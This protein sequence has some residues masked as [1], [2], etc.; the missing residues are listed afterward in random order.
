MNRQ[1]R[2][3]FAAPATN[4]IECKFVLE[5][6]I[7]YLALK[8]AKEKAIYNRAGI[9]KIRWLKSLDMECF[10][11]GSSIR[12]QRRLQEHAVQIERFGGNLDK[13]HVT[14]DLAKQGFDLIACLRTEEKARTQALKLQGKCRTN[15]RESEFLF[16][17]ADSCRNSTRGLSDPDCRNISALPLSGCCRSGFANT[18]YSQ[19]FVP[20]V[21]SPLNIRVSVDY[22]SPPGAWVSTQEDFSVQVRKCGQVWDTDIGSKRLSS[23]GLPN[24]MSF[25]IAA[26]APGEKYYIRIY[27]RSSEPLVADYQISQ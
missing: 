25:S 11:I 7:P 23:L 24:T 19:T 14:I 5:K 15:I 18:C 8:D 17:T 3:L 2:W 4:P 13:Y 9:Y 21:N 12:V 6:T 27:S 10:Y 16:E 22:L 20:A 26:V 1:D